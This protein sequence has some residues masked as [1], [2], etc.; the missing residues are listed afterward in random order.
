[1]EKRVPLKTILEADKIVQ[2]ATERK[3]ISQII[4]VV[5]YRSESCL[6]SIV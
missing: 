2:H 4:K 5:A 1:M 6:A 3:T